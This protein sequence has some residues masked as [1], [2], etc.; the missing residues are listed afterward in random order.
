[1]LNIQT[2][3]LKTCQTLI[4]FALAGLSMQASA[5]PVASQPSNNL[6]AGTLTLCNTTAAICSTS[7]RTESLSTLNFFNTYIL[8]KTIEQIRVALPWYQNEVNL[9]NWTAALSP[10]VYINQTAVGNPDAVVRFNMIGKIY[11]TDNILRDFN[12]A[13]TD[14]TT[15]NA[16]GTYNFLVAFTPPVATPASTTTTPSTPV[17]VVDV[18]GIITNAISL[19]NT[20]ETVSAIDSNINMMVYGAHSRP[21]SHLVAE[22]EKTAWVAGDIGRDDHGNRS[23]DTGLA[24]INAG[25]NFGPAQVNVTLGQTWA[26]QRLAFGGNLSADGQYVMLEAIAPISQERKL[27]AVVSGFGHWG[28]ADIRRGY[29]TRGLLSASDADADSTTYGVRAR[30][31]WMDAKELLG[32][33]LSPYADV[34]YVKSHVD[35]YTEKNGTSNASFNSRNDDNTT[36]RIGFNAMRPISGTAFNIVANLEAAHA[37]SDEIGAVSGQL[38]GTAFSVQGANINQDW[39]KAGVGVEGMVGK[40]KGK[41][42]VMLNGTTTSGLPNAWLAVS[43]QMNF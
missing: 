43:Y 13:V 26:N 34:S 1:M 2:F 25:Y 10:F 9:T 27:Y 6:T 36:L 12:Q 30:V 32:V 39:V 38:A 14:G 33:Q 18:L 24:E 5:Q 7:V 17:I 8:G 19:Q 37:F 29:I 28:E 4:G 20:T 3:K 42:S 11:G 41:G 16:T 31:E 22:G 35:G 15:A 40:G 23:G 21:L